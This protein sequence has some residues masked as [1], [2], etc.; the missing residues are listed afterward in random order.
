MLCRTCWH[1]AGAALHVACGPTSTIA[2]LMLLYLHARC[3]STCLPCSPPK[4]VDLRGKVAV[5]TGE[6]QTPAFCGMAGDKCRSA[7][8]PWR[9]IGL[10]HAGFGRGHSLGH[11]V[12]AGT[13]PGCM[14]CVNRQPRLQLSQASHS[15]CILAAHG[16]NI[17]ALCP[18]DSLSV[19][20]I[21]L[22]GFAQGRSL[23]SWAM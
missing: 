11:A 9:W 1:C 14:A 21:T 15:T 8:C 5:V 6:P 20:L 16:F 13:V 10:M 7:L 23:S 12:I 18:C 3:R 17:R 22:R 4:D 19:G 2:V